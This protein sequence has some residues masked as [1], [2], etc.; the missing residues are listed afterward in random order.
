MKPSL[1]HLV[2][3]LTI[4]SAYKTIGQVNKER[5]TTSYKYS[6]IKQFY[7]PIENGTPN[8]S[9]RKPYSESQFDNNGNLINYIFMSY[10]SAFG[11]RVE[12]YKYENNRKVEQMADGIRSLCTYNNSGD[13]LEVKEYGRKEYGEENTLIRRSLYA[14][15]SNGKKSVVTIYAGLTDTVTV[16]T[17]YTYNDRNLPMQQ[18]Y[19]S[20]LPAERVEGT[21]INTYDSSDKI[22][23]RELDASQM[24]FNEQTNY[25]YDDKGRVVECTSKYNVDP[26]PTK[27]IYSYNAEGLVVK[28]HYF[29]SGNEAIIDY[30]YTR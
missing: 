27:H 3:F 5:R 30:V 7:T 12:T 13:T 16:K 6:K 18:Q 14:Y 1:M 19:S 9:K 26:N 25:V 2:L 23:K 10:D 17:T 15:G 24:K 20:F 22:I 21:V 29:W 4:T 8:A 28:D 11:K